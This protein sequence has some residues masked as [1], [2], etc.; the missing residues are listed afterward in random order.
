MELA[1]EPGEQ[2]VAEG[3]LEWRPVEERGRRPGSGGEGAVGDEGEEGLG[4]RSSRACS[5]VC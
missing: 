4:K 5:L 2:L 3:A 1:E